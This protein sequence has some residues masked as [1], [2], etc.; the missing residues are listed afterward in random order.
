MRLKFALSV[1]AAVLCV[2]ALPGALWAKPATSKVV[3]SNPAAVCASFLNRR[4]PASAFAL[5]TGDAVVTK[6]ALVQYQK[7][8]GTYC[9]LK[10]AIR[11]KGAEGPD[12]LFQVNLPNAWNRKTVLYGGGGSNGFVMKATGAYTG[13]GG[14]VPT[15]LSLGYVTYGSDSGHQGAGME[16]YANPT[17]FANYSHAAI[18]RTKDLVSVLVKDYY[19]APAR[20]NYHIGG[21]KGGQ[22]ALQAA[23]RYYADFDGVVSNYPAAQAGSMSIAWNRMAHYAYGIPGG[24]LTTENQALLKRSVMKSCDAL[25]G[26]TDGIVSNVKACVATFKLSELRCA[27]DK[28]A[29]DCL[30]PPQ[31]TA[32][33]VAA[34]PFIFAHPMP[35]GVTSVGPFPALLGSDNSIWFGNGTASSVGGFYTPAPAFPWALDGAKVEE[36]TWKKSVLATAEIYDVSS[37]DFDGFHKRGGKLLLLQGT[38]DMLV[39]YTMTDAFF[40]RMQGRYGKRIGS[41]ARYYVVPGFG[42]GSG[43]F[44]AEWDALGALDTWVETGKAPKNPIV[45]DQEGAKVGRTRPLCEYPAYPK[46]KGVGS[47]DDAASF[48]CVKN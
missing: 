18:K 37:P 8:N 12:I 17:A 3:V 39:P 20:R 38:L 48:T 13:G 29:P 15:P 7:G 43:D 2:S 6:A 26:A 22:E 1:G 30:T 45:R 9:R 47:I 34:R 11:A 10:G 46:Y 41:F 24:A 14:N 27:S 5:P 44:S 16:F 25:D 28:P 19:G 23:Q 32:L 35:N 31:I 36:E 40:E 33:E 42:H 4:V 21:S